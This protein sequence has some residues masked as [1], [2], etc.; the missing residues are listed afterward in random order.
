MVMDEPTNHLDIAS[1]EKLIQALEKY[2]GTLLFVSH[3]QS[4]VNQLATKIWDIR[5]EAVEVYH[6]TLDEYYMHLARQDAQKGTSKENGS[7]AAGGSETQAKGFK[8]KPDRKAEK[9][10]KAERRRFIHDSLNPIKKKIER[11][12]LQISEHEVRQKEIESRLAD[13][14]L[15]KDTSRS[16]PLLG[17]YHDLRTLLDGLFEKWETLQQELEKAEQKLGLE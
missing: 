1:S 10:A 11:V 12:E 8:K 5:D 4:F 13:P 16:V 6:G 7:R 3:N 17:E 14:E 2:R 9:R 15:F